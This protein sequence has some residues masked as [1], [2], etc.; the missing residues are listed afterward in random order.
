MDGWTEAQRQTVARTVQHEIED[1]RLAQKVIPEYALPGSARAVSADTFDEATGG[2][3]DVTQLALLERQDPFSLTR[4]QAEDE[5]LS[6]ALVIIRRSA[7]RLAKDHD[8]Q[9]FRVAIRDPINAGAPPNFNVVVLVKRVDDT[10]DGMVP[11]TAAA[12]AALDG[13]GYRSGYV[14]IAGLDI[15]RLLHNRAV[16]AAD[17]PIVAVRGLLADGPVYRSDVLADD[18]ALILSVG[19]GRIDRAVS[20]APITEFLRVERS[21]AGDEVRLWRLYERYLT[22]FKETKSAVLLRLEPAAVGAAPAEEAATS[23]TRG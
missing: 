13:A 20:V 15:Y 14:M 4:A 11:A 16:G 5:D 10:G 6:S 18:E 3:D 19:A 17:L 23:R 8:Q 1:S 2:V 22:R 7:Q 12:I 9:V 21:S